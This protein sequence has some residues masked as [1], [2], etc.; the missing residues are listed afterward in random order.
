[1]CSETRMKKGEGERSAGRLGGWGVFL[2]FAKL[3][4]VVIGS[5]NR[6]GREKGSVQVF[7][8]TYLEMSP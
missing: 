1:M 7:I 2:L 6:T 4:S 3:I 5:E 8:L